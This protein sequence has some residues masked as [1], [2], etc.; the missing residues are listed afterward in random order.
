MQSFP[1]YRHTKSF[2]NNSVDK[3][4]PSKRGLTDH[5]ESKSKANSRSEITS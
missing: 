3:D 4:G 5:V 1:K 2:L